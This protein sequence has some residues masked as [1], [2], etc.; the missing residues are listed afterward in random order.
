MSLPASWALVPVT[1]T[2]ANIDGSAPNGT[3][4]FVSEQLVKIGGVIIVPKRIVARVVA[5]V[6]VAGFTLPSTNDPDLSVTGWAYTVTENFPGGRVP[7]A[8]FIGYDSAGIDLASV[9]PVVPPP[10]LVSTIGPVGPTGPAAQWVQMTQA[11]YNAAT[12]DPAILY[13]VIG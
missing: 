10:E 9:V 13:L 12:I 7:Y 11:A 3:I 6:I 2:Y 4:S 8:I 5:G 1:A